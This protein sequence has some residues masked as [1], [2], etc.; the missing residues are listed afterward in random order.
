MTLPTWAWLDDWYE[1]GVKRNC[2]DTASEK[3]ILDEFY[4][5]ESMTY[6]F[7]GVPD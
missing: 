2:L 1:F 4:A 5:C 7:S 6:M 3:T